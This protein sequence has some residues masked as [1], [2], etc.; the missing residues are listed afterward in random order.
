MDKYFYTLDTV[1]R[2]FAHKTTTEDLKDLMREDLAAQ[3]DAR[4]EANYIIRVWSEERR[5]PL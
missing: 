3:H 5:K 1:Y 2:L 4:A